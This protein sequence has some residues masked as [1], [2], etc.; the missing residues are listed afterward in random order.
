VVVKVVVVAT[1]IVE[2]GIGRSSVLV[3]IVVLLVVIVPS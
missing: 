1:W 3:S 2:K